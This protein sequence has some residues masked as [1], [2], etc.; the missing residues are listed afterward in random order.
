MKML[1]TEPMLYNRV[2]GTIHIISWDQAS[3]TAQREGRQCREVMFNLGNP[4]IYWL[5]EGKVFGEMS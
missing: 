1:N 5:S 4:A 2:L 3:S